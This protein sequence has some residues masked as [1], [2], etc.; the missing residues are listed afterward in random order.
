MF[1]TILAVPLIYILFQNSQH[2][3]FFSRAL[4]YLIGIVA[5]SI[6]G[7]IICIKTKSNSHYY[8]GKFLNALVAPLLNINYKINGAPI[9]E[10]CVYV[11]NHQSSLDLL[12]MGAMFPRETVMMVKEELKYY[13]I[14]GQYLYFS[15]CV[16]LD[17]KN[18]GKAI[19]SLN[20]VA[21]EMKAKNLSLFL[22]PE[23]TR[24]HQNDNSLLPFKKGFAHIAINGSLPVV[25]VVVSTYGDIYNSKKFLFEGG[26]INIDILDK[27]DTKGMDVDSLMNITRERM[28]AS[29][30]KNSK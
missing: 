4:I 25:P 15:K 16:L 12:P 24:S 3:R 27:I 30:E 19:D 11:C 29:L 26:T 17:R 1:S 14:L 23:G 9:D 20:N 28:Q 2:F 13:P 21:V 5:S 6:F 8:V 18:R 22:F 10:P 7:L